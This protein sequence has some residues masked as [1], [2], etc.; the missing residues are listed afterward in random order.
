M[1]EKLFYRYTDY[2]TDQNENLDITPE[3]LKDR[4]FYKDDLEDI[5]LKR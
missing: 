1:W 2:D 5:I 3:Y 4:L